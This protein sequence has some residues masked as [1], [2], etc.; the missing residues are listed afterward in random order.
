MPA[1]SHWFGSTVSGCYRSNSDRYRC[2]WALSLSSRLSPQVSGCHRA[3]RMSSHSHLERQEKGTASLRVAFCF[4]S[5][6]TPLPRNLFPHRHLPS[7]GQSCVSGLF[8]IHALTDHWQERWSHCD[9]L[10]LVNI[11]SL[12]E[13]GK[14]HQESEGGPVV[15]QNVGSISREVS[16]PRQLSEKP[17][18]WPRTPTAPGS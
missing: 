13:V 14:G 7:H 10:T 2:S 9:W 6:G 4:W 11:S 1:V 15:H 18:G 12:P 5:Q 3:R 17:Q 16:E 8:V